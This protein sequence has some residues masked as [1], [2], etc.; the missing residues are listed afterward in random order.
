MPLAPAIAYNSGLRALPTARIEHVSIQEDFSA[1]GVARTQAH[2]LFNA[3][4]AVGT[5]VRLQRNDE[6]SRALFQLADLQRRLVE[7]DERAFVP[8]ADELTLAELYLGFER[9]RFG[10]AMEVTFDCAPELREWPVPNLILLPLVENAVKHGVARRLGRG[11]VTVCATRHDDALRLEVRN[12]PPQC[13]KRALAGL[14]FGLRS[15]RERVAALYGDGAAFTFT[16]SAPHGVVATLLLPVSA[17][18]A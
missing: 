2:F 9:V 14:G 12:D 5:L 10:D 13:D 15:V 7:H 17:P 3:L 8:L 4:H 18:H 1:R 11:R 16:A 6:A